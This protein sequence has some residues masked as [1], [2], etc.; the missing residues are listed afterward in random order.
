MS[1]D[2]IED[3]KDEITRVAVK[4]PVFW[5]N[6]VEPWFTSIESQ[7]AIAGITEEVTKYHYVVSALDSDTII[8]VL[9]FV[10]SASTLPAPYTGLKQRLIEQF[11][12]S[13]TARLRALISDME[14]GDKKPSHLLR[15]MENLAAD[16]LT[17]AMLRMLWLKRLP[18]NVQQILSV[19]TDT[20]PSLALTADKITEISQISASVNVIDGNSSLQSNSIH[21]ELDKLQKKIQALE[22]SVKKLHSR[23]N[24][25][26]IR[27]RSRSRTR[28]QCLLPDPSSDSTKHCW[29]HKTFKANARKCI[30]PCTFKENE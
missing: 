21:A 26:R 11:A 18:L 13:E 8:H 27:S 15:E 17:P 10:R 9:D 22:I 23:P 4:L 24:S 16:K 7:F 1:K 28:N 14:L 30:P 19:S 3:K 5:K 12:D 2:G 20:L 25:F 29:Y 6:S